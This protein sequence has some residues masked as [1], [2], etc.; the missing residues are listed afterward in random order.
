MGTGDGRKWH[1]EGEV[2]GGGGWGEGGSELGVEGREVERQR[3]S[4]SVV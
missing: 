2:K 3:Q 1:R 4:Q